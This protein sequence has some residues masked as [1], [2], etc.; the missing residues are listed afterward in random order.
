MSH[1]GVIDYLQ[2]KSC[3]RTLALALVL[4]SVIRCAYAQI[5]PGELSREHSGLD[6]PG[7]CTDCH[8]A[9][10][11]PPEFKCNTCH[12][13]IRQRVESNRGFHAYAC[14]G[15]LMGRNCAKCHP[16]HNGRNFGLINWGG[17]VNQFDHGKAGYRLEGKHGQANCRS[18]HQASH[19]PAEAKGLVYQKDLNRT[20]LGLSVQCSSCHSD[21]HQGQLSTD[22]SRCHETTGWKGAARFEHRQAR[23]QLEGAHAK[24]ACEKCHKPAGSSKTAI[25]YKGIPSEDCSPCHRDPHINAFKSSCKTCHVSQF[26]WKAN[27]DSAV[28]KHEATKFPLTGKH[29]RVSCNSCHRGADVGRPLVFAKCRD[30]HTKDPHR[31]QF[32]SRADG[33]DC[34]GCH[35]VEGF[36]PSTFG[37]VQH[38]RT[39]FVLRARHAETKC[40][41]CHVPDKAGT[42]YRI[43]E[44]SCSS[45]HRDV[46]ESQ[47]EG[48]PYLNR[49]ES[50]HGEDRFKPSTFTLVKH[51]ATRF[52]LVD[53]HRKVPCV[54][55]HKASSKPAIFRYENSACTT[56]HQDPHQGQFS[57]R[58]A[59]LLPGGTVAGCSACHT[60]VSWN[61][62]NRF[63]HTTTGFLLEGGHKNVACDKCHK[64]DGDNLRLGKSDFKQISSRCSACHDDI[65]ENQFSVRMAGLLPDGKPSDCRSCHSE[66]DWKELA[67]FDHASTK[68]PLDGAHRSADCIKCHQSRDKGAIRGIRFADASRE[69]SGCHQDIHAGQFAGNCVRCH[70][71]QK[72]SPSIFNHDTQSS[73]KLTGAHRNVRCNLCHVN[74]AI[75]GYKTV[76]YKG[77][78]SECSACHEPDQ[79][80]KRL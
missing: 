63:D 51:D 36:K 57:A 50:C 44:F 23:F 47:F 26:D 3:I 60:M 70:I 67:G 35:T 8:D 69:C 49:C 14:A 42:I 78:A 65:H 7:H 2:S 29:M 39:K 53:S 31:E 59:S 77:T 75:N 30:C 34:S 13:D 24:V 40:D 58:M 32:A 19:I 28:A 64:G 61:D 71:S 43:N 74:R 9:G 11:R 46:H 18:C 15:D 27:K 79:L 21:A 72:W 48:K 12:R 25:K 62:L 66:R 45:C 54:E 55:C 16:E 17:S 5:S 76:I 52:P 20:Y 4:V 37:I 41:K 22:C 80:G 68:F 38:N 1:S 10:K 33:G 6:G 56:C 73:F